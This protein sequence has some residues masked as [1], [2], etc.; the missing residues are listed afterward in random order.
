M[1]SLS[2]LNIS[3]IDKANRFPKM[4]AISSI[5]GMLSDC[6]GATFVLDATNDSDTFPSIYILISYKQLLHKHFQMHLQTH[7]K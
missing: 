7:A 6:K 5:R 3:A 2:I 1:Y 4:A